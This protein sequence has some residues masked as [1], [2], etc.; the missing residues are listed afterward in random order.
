M[1]ARVSANCRTLVHNLC[2]QEKSKV[3]V[4]FKPMYLEMERNRFY[5]LMKRRDLDESTYDAG[6]S[7]SEGACWRTEEI[8]SLAVIVSKLRPWAPSEIVDHLLDSSVNT[9]TELFRLIRQTVFHETIE[10]LPELDRIL[11]ARLGDAKKIICCHFI[12]PARYQSDGLVRA[13]VRRQQAELGFGSAMF[14]AKVA[15]Q[16]ECKHHFEENYDPKRTSTTVAHLRSGM[17]DL[18]HCKGRFGHAGPEDSYETLDALAHEVVE[19]LNHL[20]WEINDDPNILSPELTAW[21]S[22]FNGIVSADDN[23]VMTMWKGGVRTFLTRTGDPSRDH[24]L[25]RDLKLLHR[26]VSPAHVMHGLEQASMMRHLT[27]AAEEVERQETAILAEEI[28]HREREIL[29]INI[30]EKAKNRD[31]SVAKV[32]LPSRL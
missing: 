3:G 28:E 8:R 20:F 4:L 29:R 26:L 2:T 7:Q 23:F 17:D 6:D 14:D 19:G 25:D 21:V 31:R 5:R 27:L 22:Q 30:A 16:R 1:N 24:L 18:R 9:N 32:W 13:D 12:M 15:F 10:S 11:K